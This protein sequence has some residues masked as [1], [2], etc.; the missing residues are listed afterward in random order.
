MME[1]TMT[2]WSEGREERPV[3]NPNS[4]E[5]APFKLQVSKNLL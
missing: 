5:K 4:D 1:N 3:L 2:E